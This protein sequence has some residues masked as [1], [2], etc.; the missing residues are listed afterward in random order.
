MRAADRFAQKQHHAL[1]E[2]GDGRGCFRFKA[3]NGGEC[4]A[5]TDRR[6]A[7]GV[8]PLPEP[9]SNHIPAWHLDT[10]MNEN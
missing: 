9:P 6:F 5:H 10:A 7:A 8:L 2:S 3:R 1:S 4:H